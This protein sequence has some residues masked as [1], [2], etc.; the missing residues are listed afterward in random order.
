MS[1]LNRINLK[2]ISCC[3]GHELC[4]RGFSF[5]LENENNFI[6]RVHL[7]GGEE[8]HLKMD[9]YNTSQLIDELK[10]YL[11]TLKK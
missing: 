3:C 8:K 4:E 9:R 6:L 1:N 7:E 10:D 2:T 11:K 5:D